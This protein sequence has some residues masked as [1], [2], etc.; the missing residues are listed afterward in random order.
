VPDV[1]TYSSLISAYAK[2]T[3]PELA[4]EHFENMMWKELCLM[5]LLTTL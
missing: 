4:L 2:G 5:L 3:Q 1:I